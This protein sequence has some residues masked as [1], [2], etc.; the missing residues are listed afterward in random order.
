MRG[1]VGKIYHSFMDNFSSVN[2]YTEL[3]MENIYA[4]GSLIFRRRN[5]PPGLSLVAKRSLLV[6]LW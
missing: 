3:L 5:F 6:L 2:L 1:L 4:T